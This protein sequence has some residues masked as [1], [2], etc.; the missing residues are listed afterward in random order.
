MYEIS[1]DI[2]LAAAFAASPNPY[3]LLTPDLHYAGMNQAYLAVV[4]VSDR[5]ELI[6]KPLFDVFTA[7]EGEG[8]PESVK[9]L[10]ASFEKVLKTGK[11]DHIALIRYAMPSGPDGEFEDR[12]WSA[13]H[14]PV[15][16]SAGEL[17]YI[18]Q[19]T[20]DVTELERLRRQS[21]ASERPMVVSALDAI[22]G[23]DL[24]R[25]AKIVQ[26]DNRRLEIERSRLIEMF[27]QAPGFVAVL[28]GPNHQFQLF[29][30]AYRRIA[31]YRDLQDKTVEEALPEVRGQG[32]IDMLDNVYQTGKPF[33]G[34]NVPVQIAGPEGGVPIESYL[35][36]IYQPIRDD[37]GE[38]VGIFVQGFDVSDT[39]LAAERQKLMIDELNHRVKNTLATVQSI[40]MQTA[41]T[42]RDPQ[43]FADS[44]QSR[45]LAM[46]HTHDLLTRS[47]WEGA[48]LRD[49]LQHET[50]AHDALRVVLNGPALPLGPAA[51]LSLGM[52]F[53]ELATNA[54]KYGALSCAR[55]RV[56]IDWS[57]TG[58]TDRRLKL[59]WREEGGPPVREPVRRGFGTRLIERNI[60]HDL[61]GV[62]NLGYRPTGFIAEISFPL[63]RGHQFE[64]TA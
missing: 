37:A 21:S 38:V 50:L 44:F 29:N 9:I 13:T 11:E 64:P 14:T 12:Y 55:G 35:D 39:V 28:S 51:A 10:R 58:S 8:A 26:D 57:I 5:A 25:R 53:H 15:S 24:L 32:F 48:D 61:A 2:D 16:N 34:R 40:A 45:L 4:G 30:E 36:F 3:M 7:G 27:M 43:T 60:R 17:A 54:A 20:A 59:V 62:V 6:G 42:H 31:A 47:H 18:L 41:R 1:S 52:I 23:G 19:H 63:N 49:I 46:S 33:Q 56:F 22:I